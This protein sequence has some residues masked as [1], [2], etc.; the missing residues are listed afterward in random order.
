MEVLNNLSL[1]AIMD[2]NYGIHLD[3]GLPWYIPEDIIFYKETIL[4]SNIIMGRNTFESMPVP[5]FSG[6]RLFVISSKPLDEYYN[7]DCFNSI[8]TMLAYVKMKENEKF[9][10]VGGAQT[11]EAFMPYVSTMYLTQI[12]EHRT[13][14]TYFPKFDIKDWN[15]TLLGNFWKATTPYI[16]K[17]YA[18]IKQK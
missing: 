12:L 11:Y 9:I 10:V 4:E 8:E 5:A 7:V 17:K 15:I 1:I 16:R 13:V 2:K 18:R 6:R 14:G 3:D